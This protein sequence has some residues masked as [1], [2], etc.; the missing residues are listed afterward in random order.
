MKIA[1]EIL[2]MNEYAGSLSVDDT[3]PNKEPIIVV[4][5][6]LFEVND[7]RQEG[8][9]KGFRLDPW[10]GMQIINSLIEVLS[11]KSLQLEEKIIAGTNADEG[12]SDEIA[13][14]SESIVA[15]YEMIADI[16]VDLAAI[17]LPGTNVGVTF[18]YEYKNTEINDFTFRNAFGTPND[19]SFSEFTKDL[20]VMSLF[21]HSLITMTPANIMNHSCLAFHEM[22][23]RRFEAKNFFNLIYTDETDPRVTVDHSGAEQFSMLEYLKGKMR[24]DPNNTKEIVNA[25]VKNK[26]TDTYSIVEI[27]ASTL[28]SFAESV[29]ADPKYYLPKYPRLLKEVD[30]IIVFEVPLI[31]IDAIALAV[32]GICLPNSK[33]LDNVFPIV[34]IWSEGKVDLSTTLFGGELGEYKEL[35][36]D[37]SKRVPLEVGWII[38]SEAFHKI[39]ETTGASG[40]LHK[41][42]KARR[43]SE[44]G[45]FNLQLA[46]NGVSIEGVMNELKIISEHSNILHLYAVS[47]KKRVSDVG[48]V[49]KN[50]GTISKVIKDGINGVIDVV[51]DFLPLSVVGMRTTAKAFIPSLV[52]SIVINSFNP[53]NF[54]ISPLVRA[55][56]MFGMSRLAGIPLRTS[57]ILSLLQIP[58]WPAISITNPIVF[59][60]LIGNMVEKRFTELAKTQDENFWVW[61]IMES[62]PV[63]KN[64]ARKFRKK[65]AS[66]TMD[67]VTKKNLKVKGSLNSNCFDPKEVSELTGADYTSTTVGGII[68]RYSKVLFGARNE[69]ARS[70]IRS[71]LTLLYVNWLHCDVDWHGIE[72]YQRPESADHITNTLGGSN[73]K[74]SKKK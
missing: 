71:N 26:L 68:S 66:T 14:I 45:L 72:G 74:P 65:V 49:V 57:I 44:K 28:S 27:S 33:E 46:A 70:D 34:S 8:I 40:D 5:N 21:A 56:I 20:Y 25:E 58:A 38:L 16:N 2:E 10:N 73:V 59:S 9:D 19:M 47:L 15:V 32:S 43:L 36:T 13:E 17:P 53:L 55:P 41:F 24:V 50:I 22:W 31:Y 37:I 3:H 51:D 48:E 42:C 67:G 4:N 35:K 60:M 63:I 54:L 62:L 29:A 18:T 69:Q 39:K 11:K 7:P 1:M 64:Q 12:L 52:L 6:A 30:G 23:S 61:R